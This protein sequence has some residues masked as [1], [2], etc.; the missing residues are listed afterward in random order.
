MFFTELYSIHV[1]VAVWVEAGWA[2]AAR[3]EYGA[4]AAGDVMAAS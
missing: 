1:W 3:S 2:A 4:A